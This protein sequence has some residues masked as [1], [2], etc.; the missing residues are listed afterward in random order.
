MLALFKGLG[1]KVWAAILIAGAIAIA[2]GRAIAGIH[3]AGR[4]SKEVEQARET[5]QVQKEFNDDVSETLK[6]ES[7]LRHDIDAGRVSLRED[8]GYK[9]QPKR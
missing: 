5:I 8:D 6:A 1:I 2:V 4:D 7:E 9:R 3:K